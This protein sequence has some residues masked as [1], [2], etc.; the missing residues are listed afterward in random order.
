MIR[1]T[2]MPV[3]VVLTPSSA[4][5]IQHLAPLL[6][7]PVPLVISALTQPRFHKLACQE[8]TRA[9][10]VR[11]H[12]S[13]VPQD[14]THYS[15]RRSA[16]SLQQVTSS[17]LLPVFHA[18]VFPDSTAQLVNPT[19]QPL[20]AGATLQLDPTDTS[21]L[22]GVFKFTNPAMSSTKCH[23]MAAQLPLLA[24]TSQP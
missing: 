5:V 16:I 4:L 19:A 6:A 15:L 3:Q 8:L 21:M 18:S 11:P 22:H 20:Q 23:S 2:S 24:T 7:K 10:L 17:H 12:A 14:T 9:A 1:L 13:L